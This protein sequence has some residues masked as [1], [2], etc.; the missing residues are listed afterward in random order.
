LSERQSTST[1]HRFL[2]EVG[3]VSDVKRQ[4]LALLAGGG[5]QRLCDVF[6]VRA[7]EIGDGGK[8]PFSL[9]GLVQG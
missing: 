1:L 2:C 7:G 8:N 9:L 6:V 4:E 3:L 5:L